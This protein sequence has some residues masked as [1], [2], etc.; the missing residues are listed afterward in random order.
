MSTSSNTTFEF[1]VNH[2]GEFKLNPLTYQDGSVLNIRVFQ[3]DFE[4][5]VSYLTWKIPRRFTT[6]YYMLPPYYT[7]S[8]MKQIKND[9]H[10]NVMYDIAKVAGKLQIFVSHSQID[11]STE[12][13]PNNGSLEESFAARQT[14]VSKLQREIQAEE[15]LA[16][17][18]LSNLNR[19][20][21]EM[22]I[23]QVQITMLQS[24]PTTSLNTYGLHALLM[25]LEADIQ[26]RLNVLTKLQE[27]LDEEAILEEQILALMHRFA[28]R[29]T[30]RRVEIN[31]LMVLHDHPL[32]EY[33]KYALGCMT[34]AD[35]KKC[36]YL[37]SVRDELL[38]SME[39]KR[40]LMTNY[41]D[42]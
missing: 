28:D 37:K 35:M 36:V 30:D 25:T 31:N 26:V 7:L 39:E 29:F 27:A 22:R 2:N 18:L 23:R 38:R 10:T 19:Y 42:M 14:I 21:E 20:S 3:M 15:T 16:Q 32:I 1:D 12:L 41:R 24:M 33:G 6:L 34:G 11:L 5:T 40:Q 8:G 4:D 17:Q 9:Y 13:I